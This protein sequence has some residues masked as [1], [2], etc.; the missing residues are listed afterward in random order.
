MKDALCLI[1]SCLLSYFNSDESPPP[2]K[3]APS[4]KVALPGKWLPWIH[5]CEYKYGLCFAY[6]IGKQG[7]IMCT[8]LKSLQAFHYSKH[9]KYLEEISKFWK[10]QAE[11]YKERSNEGTDMDS[12]DECDNGVQP[13]DLNVMVYKKKK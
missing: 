2:Q 4:W 3:V 12:Q 6:I 13:M 7:V 9:Q 10:S 8:D 11:A 5:I 1:N